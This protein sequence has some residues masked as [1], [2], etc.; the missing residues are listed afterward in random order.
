VQTWQCTPGD[1]SQAWTVTDVKTTATS[2]A[3]FPDPTTVC[4]VG[5]QEILRPAPGTD[6]TQAVRNGVG[7]RPTA[8]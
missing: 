1:A 2:H 7:I 3:P 4:K 5:H 6:V 8:Y